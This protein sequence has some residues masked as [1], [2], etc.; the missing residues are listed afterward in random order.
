MN[1][2]IIKKR[3]FWYIIS[4]TL[5][6]ISIISLIL[7]GLKPSI[8]FTGGTLMELKL[9]DKVYQTVDISTGNTFANFLNANIANNSTGTITVQKTQDNYFILRFK[10][11]SQEDRTKLIEALK[12]K[13][14]QDIVETK[15][16]YIGPTLGKELQ[17]NTTT[18]IIISV[19]AI[20]IYIAFAFKQV[21]YPIK[22]WKYGTIGIIALIHDI[23]IT[24][25]VFSLLGKFL[26]V[27]VDS[28]FITALLTILGYSINDT[29][30]IYDRI[31]E[32][33]RRTNGNFEDIVN[34]SLNE[35]M[36]RSI[37][38]TITTLLSL[39]AVFLFGG[40]SIKMFALA[41][42]VG[43]TLGSYSSIFVASPLLVDLYNFEN[44]KK[45]SQKK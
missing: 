21:S 3:K 31:R 35:T 25:G 11:I 41:L 30:V 17:K 6:L 13:V 40:D 43:I 34:N 15:F 39:I 19:I 28:L 9:S 14:D 36:A 1:L 18:A 4:S 16:E 33:L 42:I 12:E 38:T 7:F 24:I 2:Q 29:I 22:S 37:N 45:I 44:R 8:D 5:I 27:E 26:N 10:E 32:N 20:I 23:L